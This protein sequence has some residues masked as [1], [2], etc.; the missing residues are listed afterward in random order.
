[1]ANKGKKGQK[2]KKWSGAN[3][4][5][6][7]LGA[8]VA[9]SMVLSSVFVFGA[10]TSNGSAPLQTAPQIINNTAVPSPTVG[11]TPTPAPTKTPIP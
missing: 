9:F 8:I 5:N 1:M 10:A 11:F 3:M 7:V 6:F 2:S 4:M